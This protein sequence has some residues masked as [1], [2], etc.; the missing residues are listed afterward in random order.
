M[1]TPDECKQSMNRKIFNRNP[2]SRSSGSAKPTHAHKKRKTTNSRPS[3]KAP[4]TR[5]YCLSAKYE[6]PPRTESK[7]NPSVH[8]NSQAWARCCALPPPPPPTLVSRTAIALRAPATLMTCAPL[9]RSRAPHICIHTRV[10]SPFLLR[11]VT[12]LSR[13]YARTHIPLRFA[14]YCA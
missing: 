4:K 3:E 5:I 13:T 2:I 14:D 1:K 8:G 9:A 12:S 10:R 7:H 6:A 11:A